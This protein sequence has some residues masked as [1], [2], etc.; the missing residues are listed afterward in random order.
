MHFSSVGAATVM[1]SLQVDNAARV[2]TKSRKVKHSSLMCLFHPSCV[3]HI[4]SHCFL[5]HCYY[6]FELFGSCLKGA[7]QIS[8]PR[9]A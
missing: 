4:L 9:L 1:F 3:F 8:L 2:P 6:R 7:I 5:M